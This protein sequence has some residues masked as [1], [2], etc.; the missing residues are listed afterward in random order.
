MGLPLSCFQFC[1]SWKISSFPLVQGFE[2]KKNDIFITLVSVSL[3]F[4]NLEKYNIQTQ[5]LSFDHLNLFKR[6]ETLD[7]NRF[8]V[9]LPYTNP[10]PSFSISYRCDLYTIRVTI[11]LLPLTQ[12]SLPRWFIL[13]I[14]VQIYHVYYLC[15]SL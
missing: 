14:H 9:K 10:N 11:T 15:L 7:S 3:V 5:G 2:T 12:Y 1:L 4:H 8:M 6:I 13:S